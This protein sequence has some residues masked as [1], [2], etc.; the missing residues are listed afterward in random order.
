MAIGRFYKPTQNAQYQPLS[1]QEMA[2]APIMMRKRED[3]YVNSMNE[4]LSQL[5]NIQVHEKYQDEANELKTKI[6][7]RTNDLIEGVQR[8]GAGT[9]AH[10]QNLH[11]LRQDYNKL[12]SKTG[13]L[14]MGQD[15]KNTMDVQKQAYYKLGLEHNQSPADI[16]RNWN[17]Y[18]NNYLEKAPGSLNE[19]KGHIPEFNP[20]LPPKDQDLPG[21]L[22]KLH[23]MVGKIQEKHGDVVFKDTVLP[24]GTKSVMV[25][26]KDGNEIKDSAQ[27]NA[28]VNTVR[29][30]VTN[31]NSALY[32]DLEYKGLTPAFYLDQ[33]DQYQIGMTSKVTENDLSYKGQVDTGGNSGGRKTRTTSEES[34]YGEGTLNKTSNGMSSLDNSATLSQIYDMQEKIKKGEITTDPVEQSRLLRAYQLAERDKK[35][36]LDSYLKST[37]YQTEFEKRL[38]ESGIYDEFEDISNWEEY[39]A[40][41]QNEKYTKER[42]INVPEQNALTGD[43]RIK[44]LDKE[45]GKWKRYTKMKTIYQDPLIKPLKDKV[46]AIQ[47]QMLS[48]FEDSQKNKLFNSEQLILGSG[49]SNKELDKMLGESMGTMGTERMMDLFKTGK[50][51]LGQFENGGRSFIELSPNAEKGQRFMQYIASNEVSYDFGAINTGSEMSPPEL[52]Y[53]AIVGSGDDK[54]RIDFSIKL[55][56]NDFT[57]DLLRQDG[58]FY[59]GLNKDARLIIDN[60]RDNIEYSD[61]PTSDP[62]DIAKHPDEMFM[63]DKTNVIVANAQQRNQTEYGLTVRN[64]QNPTGMEKIIYDGMFIKPGQ[65]KV[66]YA[67]T[68]NDD[69]SYSTHK[70]NEDGSTQFYTFEDYFNR[71]NAGVF[72]LMNMNKP[73]TFTPEFFNSAEGQKWKN[74]QIARGMM[75]LYQNIGNV[76]DLSGTGMIYNNSEEFTTAMR[77]AGDIIN[78]SMADDRK[79]QELVNIYKNIKRLKVQSKRIKMVL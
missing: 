68:V 72:R 16:E 77:K 21:R 40:A 12:V 33:L 31:P 6:R 74:A 56:D 20:G 47:N 71:E 57:Q 17:A 63:R 28:L 52:I 46:T 59:K 41:L 58:D 53:S 7:Q 69:K 2:F 55:E 65:K 1:F 45:T 60:I 27:V 30:E 38:E 50:L 64:T 35:K 10:T 9:A 26:D 79:K 24:D 22:A 37:E 25:F 67:V 49:K 34:Q 29:N 73:E 13:A 18:V 11:K 43:V 8:D 15:L 78:S 3:S 75:F 44:K 76:D 36:Q 51:E 66:D 54:E 14:G 5:D 39:Q 32:E 42:P 4:V 23:Q 70:K 62:K 61:I 19:F 48:D